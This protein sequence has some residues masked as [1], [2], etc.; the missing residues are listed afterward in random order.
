MEEINSG[1]ALVGLLIKQPDLIDHCQILTNFQNPFE[2]QN[3]NTVFNNIQQ[4]YGA[5]GK[6]DRRELVKKGFPEVSQGYYLAL[7]KASG[8]DVEINKY[9]QN[10]YEAHTKQQISN[11]GHSIVNCS[12]DDLN[13]V[14]VYLKRCRDVVDGIEKNSVVS[15][16]VTIPE[17]IQEVENKIISLQTLDNKHYIK[18]GILDLDKLIIGL[19]TKKMSVIGARPSVGKSAL[20]LT[21]MSNMMNMGTACGFISL[22]MSES[23]CIERIAQMRSGVCIS[24]FSHNGMP[25]DN[26][27]RFYK[28]L[29]LIANCPNIQVSRL[30]DRRISNIRRT[31]RKMKNNNPEMRVVFI[32]YIQKALGDDPSQDMKA[33]VASISGILTDI[34][35]DMDIHVCN[36]AQLNRS[37]EDAPRLSHLKESGRIEEDAN[38]VFLIHRDLNQQHSG[39]SDSEAYIGVAKNRSGR[40][41]NI[42]I[43]YNGATTRFYDQPAEVM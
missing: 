7:S 23:E 36:M 19:E 30:T 42:Q 1:M 43:R 27:R 11:L 20:G 37:G 2:T 13:D 18:T 28:Q 31:I 38:Y 8:F 15:N 41:G 33:Q 10:V 16:G 29:E 32:D 5:T 24:E 25:Q 21:F 9:I 12:Q 39:M 34:A 40:T 6:V 26:Q 4:L 22:E 17:A 35:V 3:L 14:S